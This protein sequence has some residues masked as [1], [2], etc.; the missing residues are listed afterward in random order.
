MRMLVGAL[1]APSLNL[2]TKKC[3]C[4]Y[5]VTQSY[6][7]LCDLMDCSTPGFPVLHYLPEFAQAH[8]HWV[9]DAIQSSHHLSPLS[10]PALN[11]SQHQGLLQ[12][13]GSL[14]QVAKVLELQHQSFKWIF[15]VDFSLGLTGLISLLTKRLS[16]VFSNTTFESINSLVLS[17]LYIKK[18]II[19]YLNKFNSIG[20]ILSNL[21]FFLFFFFLATSYGTRNL[22][23]PTRNWTHFPWV[24]AW[25]PNHR[26]VREFPP[27][28]W[29]NL[30]RASCLGRALEFRETI[31]F[32]ASNVLNLQEQPLQ[33][34]VLSSCDWLSRV[35]GTVV[36][37]L[38]DSAQPALFALSLEISPPCL[39]PKSA[40]LGELTGCHLPE[41]GGLEGRGG[42]QLAPMA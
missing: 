3:N 34:C 4:C 19:K 10:P 22:S 6:L 25:H 9:G 36:D 35:S 12:W 1:R 39:L 40:C 31:L 38:G 14:H 8:V 32:Q 20:S 17:L 7:T 29:I 5:S 41:E 11:L 13:V 2:E 37:V 24:E 15:R 42:L 27:Q 33:A 30:S 26:I 21:G 18:S 28:T 23:F 16:R